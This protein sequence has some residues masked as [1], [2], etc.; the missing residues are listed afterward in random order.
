MV[1]MPMPSPKKKITF[2]FGPVSVEEEPDEKHP[3]SEMQARPA[4]T[5]NLNFIGASLLE[6]EAAI[7]AGDR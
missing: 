3:A 7:L 2:F 1:V 5:A 4:A 6:I